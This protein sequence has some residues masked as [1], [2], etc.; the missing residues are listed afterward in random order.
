MAIPVAD[1]IAADAELLGDLADGLAGG[2]ELEC[3]GLELGG[4]ALSWLG[5]HLLV[6]SS[7]R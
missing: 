6:I 5:F 2:E 4:V 7:G 1:Q 3:P